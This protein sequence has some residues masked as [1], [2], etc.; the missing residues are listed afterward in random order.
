MPREK[1]KKEK[2]FQQMIEAQNDQLVKSNVKRNLIG[3]F[4]RSE[5]DARKKN[6]MLA[7]KKAKTFAEV[8]EA[9]DISEQQ[10]PFGA[11][12]QRQRVDTPGNVRKKYQ[13]RS[14]R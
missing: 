4:A 9:A 13:G 12:T 11:A 3:K 7:P 8:E 14:V 2:I 6:P 1:S 5:R 10:V